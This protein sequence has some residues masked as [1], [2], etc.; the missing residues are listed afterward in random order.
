M[1]LLLPLHPCRA[2][3]HTQPESLIPA[4]RDWLLE[5]HSHDSARK[6]SGKVFKI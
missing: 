2:Q 1:Y 5:A 4:N 6:K 3:A